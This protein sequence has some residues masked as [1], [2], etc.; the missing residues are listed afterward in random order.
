MDRFLTRTPQQ[1][2]AKRL[3]PAW[4]KGLMIL[5]IFILLLAVMG[6]FLYDGWHRIA[7]V[8]AFTTM[9]IAN[10]A[11]GY[12]SLHPEGRFSRVALAVISPLAVVM[13]I[14]LGVTL[15]FQFGWVR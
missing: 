9:G 8:T 3:S 5:S 2:F 12:V 1:P 4:A 10:L 6:G 15:A 13:L 7:Y 11:Q 14:A